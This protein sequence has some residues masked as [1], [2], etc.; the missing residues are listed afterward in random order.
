MG[1][2]GISSVSFLIY[3]LFQNAMAYIVLSIMIGIILD[4]FA[5]VGSEARKIRV[6]DIE[7]FRDVWLKYDPKGTYVVPSHNLLAILQQLSP[8]L[9]IAGIAEPMTRS[10]MLRKLGELDIP[11][12]NGYI[13]FTETLTAMC[14]RHAGVAVPVCDSS[15]KIQKAAQNVPKI[16]AMDA[17]SNNALHSYLATVMQVKWRAYTAREG[18][19]GGGGDGP[20]PQQF[21]QQPVK[22]S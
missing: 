18:S 14:N 22:K 6:D 11:D 7:E 10:D 21:A 12:H 9:G 20:P 16:K 8:P 4:N 1:S 15:K 17:A 19:V 13:H 2:C 3:F 5:Q